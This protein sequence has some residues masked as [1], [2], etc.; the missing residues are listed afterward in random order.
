MSEA[1]KVHWES[2]VCLKTTSAMRC[3]DLQ[4][5]LTVRF[6]ATWT[7]AGEKSIQ[8]QDRPVDSRSWVKITEFLEVNVMTGS[9]T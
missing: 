6:P 4:V 8:S 2:R 1:T 9:N 7:E 3:I 5:M